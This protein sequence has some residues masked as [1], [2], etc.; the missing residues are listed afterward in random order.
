MDDVGV[1]QDVEFVALGVEFHR[2]RH[3]V[4]AEAQE[5]QVVADHVATYNNVRLEIRFPFDLFQRIA[6]L[7]D[8]S[9]SCLSL[10]HSKSSKN[11]SKIPLQSPRFKNSQEIIQKSFKTLNKN[12]SEILINPL[13]SFKIP[14]KPSKSFKNLSKSLKILKKSSSNPWKSFKNPQVIIYKSFKISQN[15]SKILQI[16]SEIP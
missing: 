4:P 9:I 6:N 7:I 12:P 16:P 11:P 15:L 5:S 13:E 10:Y 8:S 2:M 1:G 3:F 14:I